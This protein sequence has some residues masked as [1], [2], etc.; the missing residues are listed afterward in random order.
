MNTTTIATRFCQLCFGALAL[1]VTLPS[2][3]QTETQ[4]MYLRDTAATNPDKIIIRAGQA[5]LDDLEYRL[6]N[7]R[8]PDEYANEAW[9][10]GTNKAY[11]QELVRYW[12]ED[13]DW[14]AQEDW[15][16]SFDHYKTT[17]DGLG[18]HYIHQRSADPD[19]IPVLLLHGWPGSFVQM[20]NLVPLLTD[21]AAH[22]MPDAPSFHVVVASLPGFGLSDAAKAPGLAMEGFAAL[23]NTLMVDELGYPRYGARGSDLG[24]VTIDQLGRH[25]PGNLIGAHLTQIIAAGAPPNPPENATQAERDFLAASAVIGNTEIGYA[26]V[27][28]TKP[29]TLAYG[30]ND[31]PAGLAGWI[32]EKYRTWG[33]T[34]GDI[35]SRFSKDFLLTTL[36]TY[37]LTQTIAPS[38]RTYYEMYRNR[39]NGSRVGV[40]VGFLMSKKDMFPPAPREWAE[41]S[42][43]VVHFSETPTGGHFLEWEEPELVARDMQAFFGNLAGARQ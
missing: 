14:R 43:N 23:M 22:G 26:R 7:T 8:W 3:A 38:V 34:G 35:D 40:P 19:A 37:W 39:G 12:A 17:I 20:L 42:H 30:L 24:G 13:F 1:F 32:V 11:L 33:D 4:T 25:Y 15:L 36:T 9:A 18:I 10:Y 16:N 29:Q 21:P 31:S 41:R 2:E 6:R 27:H 5:A 28:S